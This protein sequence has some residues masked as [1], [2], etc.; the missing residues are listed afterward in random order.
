MNPVGKIAQYFGY[1]LA[2]IIIFGI[3]TGIVAA[4]GGILTAVGIISRKAPDLN[5]NCAAYDN[6]LAVSVG[7][8]NLV[9]KTGTEL[10]YT[11]DINDLE[12]S[13]GDTSLTIKDNSR[14]KWF[15]NNDKKTI[16]V[17]VPENMKF[18]AIG[19]TSGAGKITTEK[20]VAEKVKFDLGAGE[21]VIR[22]LEVI[23]SADIDAGMGKVTIDGGTINNANISLGVGEANIRSKLTGRSKV[24]CGIGSVNLDLL[25]P[26]SAYTI[27]ADKGIG[28]ISF[29]GNKISDNT[30]IGNGK[31][32]LSVDGGIGSV[33]IKTTP[34]K[35]EIEETIDESKEEKP[36][37]TI[38]TDET[39]GIVIEPQE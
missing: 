38:E 13:L 2:G 32:D 28:S 19:I 21:T 27:R 8:A 9:V 20:L 11:S 7:A 23:D 25:L 33:N 29:N 37:E 12:V 22:D 5:V 26:D 18:D 30:I 39:S 14:V 1:G 3:I 16:T 36:E 34:V 4:V 24:D 10:S 31:Y 17:T 6:C 15:G 35:Y